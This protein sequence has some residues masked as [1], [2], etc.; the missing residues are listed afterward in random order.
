M[1][2]TPR[3]IISSLYIA[4]FNKAPDKSG[5]DFWLIQANN[6]LGDGTATRDVY[7]DLMG[8]FVNHPVFSATYA[9]MDDATF[10]AAVYKNV[11]GQAGDTKGLAFWE[12]TLSSLSRGDMIIDFVTATLNFDS[13]NPRHTTG[14]STEDIQA[15]DE[16]QALLANKV[17]VA[18]HFVDTLKFETNINSNP[19]EED[20][21]YLA[22][23]AILEGVT[24]DPTT[25]FAAKALIDAANS[26][27]DS[28]DY[29]LNPPHPS[30][31]FTV[32]E[33]NTDFQTNDGINDANE[34][35]NTNT[36]N[37]IINATAL[38]AS[39]ATT[40]I[41]G[42]EG[43]DRL[44]ITDT[45]GM[46]SV[47]LTNNVANIE[48]VESIH[49]AAGVSE[50]QL[51]NR[52]IAGNAGGEI[53][54]LTGTADIAQKLLIAGSG[55]ADLTGLKNNN[56]EEI[57]LLDSAGTG[58]ELSIDV[59]NLNDM[60][61]LVL[62]EADAGGADTLLL[63][64]G[65]EFDFSHIDL[66]FNDTEEAN[67]LAFATGVAE[68]SATIDSEDIDNVGVITGSTVAEE[69]SIL[70]LTETTDLS[71]I[72]TTDI[73]TVTIAGT[74]STLT[75]DEPNLSA[76]QYTT[77]TGAGDS[78]LVFN[79]SDSQ[80]Q[81]ID[82][83]NTN[84]SGFVS[85]DVD[86]GNNDNTLIL[87]AN[88]ISGEVTLIGGVTTNIQITEDL[89]ASNLSVTS[90]DFDSLLLDADI[91]VTVDGD[92]FSS[93][94]FP[95]IDGNETAMLTVNLSSTT[96]D[97]G[98]YALGSS[99]DVQTIINDTTGND[100]I[101]AANTKSSGS[102]MVINLS[103]GSDAVRLNELSGNVL[104]GMSVVDAVAITGFNADADDQIN[105]KDTLTTSSAIV[106][107]Q[108]GRVDQE[109]DGIVYIDNAVMS[110]F[111]NI[112][113]LKSVV[114]DYANGDAGDK[115][116][117]VVSNT[118]K[119]EVAIYSFKEDGTNPATIDTADEVTLIGIV[120]YTGVFDTA[121]ISAF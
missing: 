56:I 60:T 43:N 49:L 25:L 11:L 95:S 113:A 91:N 47:N 42:L 31:N 88:S 30:Q 119:T 44:N 84:I 108:S 66:D 69:I 82:L 100:T 86:S 101:T 3:E 63:K 70:N 5:L 1:T 67:I 90:G 6:A 14:L 15:A 26:D 89:D 35:N 22:S 118:A 46:N 55:N 97:L 107:K 120:E 21:A 109:T 51:L 7:Q 52:D 41:D 9:N 45:T 19:P 29:L 58:R 36:G 39:S 99:S 16:R 83:T 121:D 12:A 59:A 81:D 94:P 40:V 116:V 111:S 32:K 20:D 77:I 71:T 103:D 62:D 37:D 24:D 104:D 28:I 96:L 87:G 18:L 57:S 102:N 112:N 80:D 23:I 34:G 61:R 115:M 105:V 10:V 110:D 76:K 13:S 64:G 50:I 92:I 72:V 85:I 114:G 38:Q 93:T 106:S 79:D 73:D 2:T 117:F 68:I 48:N 33:T 17:A 74:A 54:V 65:G 98:A 78:L 27:A 75:L 53:A 8:G 4:T